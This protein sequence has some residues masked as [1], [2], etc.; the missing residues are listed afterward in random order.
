[1]RFRAHQ[2]IAAALLLLAVGP[3]FGQ[4]ISLDHVDGLVDPSSVGTQRVIRFYLRVSNPGDV[5]FDGIANGF[6]VYSPDGATWF[7]TFHDTTGTLGMTQFDGGVFLPKF[8]ADGAGADTVGFGALRFFSTGLPAHFDDVA[9]TVTIGPI[10]DTD[11]GKTICLDSSYYRPSGVWKWAA[12]GG[13]DVFPG[14]SGPHCF[15]IKGASTGDS[16][17]V[18]PSS[19]E[20]TAAEYDT[21]P[22]EQWLHVGS[23]ADPMNY[24]VIPDSTPWLAVSQNGLTTPDSVLVAVFPGMAGPGNHQATIAVIAS[25]ADNSPVQVPVVLRRTPA[26]PAVTLDHFDGGLAPN[27]IFTDEEVTFYLRFTGSDHAYDGLVNGFRVY[28]PN[29]AHWT[30]TALDTTGTVGMTQF[31]LGI[32]FPKFSNDGMGADTVGFG[33]VKIVGSGLVPHFDDIALKLTIGPIDPGDVGKTI[34]LDSSWFP[35]TGDW[36]WHVQG[37]GAVPPAWDGTHCFTVTDRPPSNLVATPTELHFTKVEL[38]DNPPPQVLMVTSSGPVSDEF[39]VATDVDWLTAVGG[40]GRT[41][42]SVMVMVQADSLPIGDYVGH[43]LLE[44]PTA[45]NSPLSVPVYLTVEPGLTTQPFEIT[46][47]AMTG[48]GLEDWTARFGVREEANDGFD[49]LYDQ[50]KAPAPPGDYVRVFFPHPEWNQFSNE[51][52]T[53]IRYLLHQECKEWHMVVQTNH[54]TTVHLGCEFMSN[55][56]GYTISLFNELGMLL[57]EDFKR[58]GYDFTTSGGDTHFIIRVCDYPVFYGRYLSGWSLVSSPLMLRDPAPDA[59]FGDDAVF[60]QLYGWNGAYQSPGEV[61]GRTAG[62]WLLL[63][64]ATTV[65]YEGVSFETPDG[66][67]CSELRVGW[68]LTGCPYNHAVDVGGV[69]IDSAGYSLSYYDAAAAGWISPVFYGWSGSFYFMSPELHPGY[70]YWLAALV[71][72]L[73]LCVGE[74]VPLA[75][76]ERERDGLPNA[77][78][79]GKAALVQLGLGESRVSIGLAEDAGDGFD[80]RY[81]L[82]APPGSPAGSASKLVLLA[83]H[84]N[85][86]DEYWQDVRGLS[87]EVVWSLRVT[88][89]GSEKITFGSLA[90]WADLGYEVTMV[91]AE[92]GFQK[93]VVSGLE[94]AVPSGD[95]RIV[96]H[97]QSQS[98]ESMP[99]TWY[100]SANYPNPFNP[101][102]TI[103][104]GLPAPARVRLSVYNILGQEVVSLV[105]GPLPAGNHEVDWDGRNDQGQP[106]SSG[107]YLYRLESDQFRQTRKM[108]L[109]K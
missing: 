18:W 71:P 69:W 93:T 49:P 23:T 39:T 44:S 43:V 7:S 57:S 56:Y 77:A 65:D 38:E 70:G 72:G 100:L 73:Q 76:A 81:D 47:H 2:I 74:V 15:N 96:A 67:P 42:D 106:V 58:F 5:P 10:P 28:S 98:P 31:D 79:S 62:Y 84:P 9:F 107:I 48:S 103:A 30:T 33:A 35:P 104:F 95:Y 109:I 80:S 53:D 68:N 82:P 26:G 97:R 46:V 36:L 60:Y 19:L 4:S 34:C 78:L 87:D 94:L 85:G 61:V 1:M 41:P 37:D 102:T 50:F 3:A 45:L 105:D 8:S 108:M 40:M 54:A 75:D 24:T 66:P 55:P 90:D 12:S 11:A 88:S 89:D 99:T 83:D 101:R 20:F 51:F 25:G 27:Q 59:V 21:M 29:G 14:W 86:F 17:I 13:L 64:Q 52:A 32:F 6:R 22:M 16:L 92:G 91:G 63:P